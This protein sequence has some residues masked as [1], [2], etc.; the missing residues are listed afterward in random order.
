LR[1]FECGLKGLGKFF[2]VLGDLGMD[3]FWGLWRL[4]AS[5]WICI[6]ILFSILD[7]RIEI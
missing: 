3:F 1:D 2:E 4:A 5:Y 7:G 6:G